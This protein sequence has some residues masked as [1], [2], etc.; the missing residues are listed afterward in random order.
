[1]R[2]ISAQKTWTATPCGSFGFDHNEWLKRLKLG[3]TRSIELVYRI[4]VVN[5]RD[6]IGVVAWIVRREYLLSRADSRLR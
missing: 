1:M 2:Q 6:V 3:G 5:L 4:R